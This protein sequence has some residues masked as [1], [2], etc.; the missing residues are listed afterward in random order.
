MNSTII[1]SLKKRRT[2]YALGRNVSLEKDALTSLVTDA[3]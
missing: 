3:I 2:Q 1:E